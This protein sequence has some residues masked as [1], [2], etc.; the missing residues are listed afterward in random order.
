M[1]Y[2]LGYLQFFLYDKL[3]LFDVMFETNCGP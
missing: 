3:I 2:C 1:Q